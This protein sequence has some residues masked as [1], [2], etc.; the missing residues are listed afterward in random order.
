M[1]TSTFYGWAEPDNSSL[2]KNGAA[3][4]RTLGDA[5]DTSVWNVGFGQAGKNYLINADFAINQRNFSTL[6][7]NGYGFDRWGLLYGGAGASVTYS[8][9]TFTAGAAPVAPY[10]SRNFARMATTT[11]SSSSEY[12]IFQQ[13]IEDVRTTAGKTLTVSFW[14]KAASGTPKVGIELNQ[15]FGSGGSGDVS[16]GGTAVTISTSWAR[17]SATINVPSISGKTVGTSSFTEMNLWCSAGSTF[18]SRS[19]SVGNQ[20]ATIDFSN[21]QVEYGSKATPFDLAG[22]GAQQAELALC[23][24]YFLAF[25]TA[26]AS[27]FEMP[28]G[29]QATT[30]TSNHQIQLPVTMRTTPS[31]SQSA[32]GDW[33]VNNNI[34]QPTLT[35]SSIFASRSGTEAVTIANGWSGAIGAVAGLV[36]MI[37]N[38]T[39]ARYYLSAEL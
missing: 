25:N 3:D 6:T 2:V 16:S 18:N 14:A 1:A 21:V 20:T 8:A 38:K 37:A 39:A 11:G 4:I 33:T 9:Q 35:S 13:K 32:I 19:G 24:R 7:T 15:N 5:I 17:Y 10:E 34:N 31:A 23:Q 36:E 27:A 26:A 29:M 28:M 30:T 22:G 12:S